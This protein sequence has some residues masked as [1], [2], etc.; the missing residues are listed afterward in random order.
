MSENGT[1]TALANGRAGRA[2]TMEDVAREAGVSRALVSI[3]F[4]GKPG[5]SE[6]TR[7]RVH[8]AAQRIGYELNVA[9]RMLRETETNVVGLMMTLKN[10]FH[11]DIAEKLIAAAKERSME[12]II[13]A[14][15]QDSAQ[16]SAVTMMRGFR[17]AGAILLGTD[18][19]ASTVAQLSSDRP[20][21]VVGEHDFG[22]GIDIVRSDDRL[23]IRIAL[24]Y[25]LGKGHTEIAYLSSP[26]GQAMAERREAYLEWMAEHSME[27]DVVETEDTEAGGVAGAGRLLGRKNLPTATL[28]CN[29]RCAIGMASALTDAGVRIPEDISVVGFDDIEQARYGIKLT[30]I[31]QDTDLLAETAM[32]SLM[33]RLRDPDSDATSIIFPPTL[34]ERATVGPPAR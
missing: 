18:V 3:V 34:V 17:V 4:R 12:I 7:K 33:T 20:C 25:L 19:Q 14:V 24:D 13:G 2:P 21:V 16:D 23:G 28:A 27:A 15:G 30:T 9:A 1:T 5:A 32:K 26:H 22:Q 29:D 8:E 6:A 31:H 11:T 10:P